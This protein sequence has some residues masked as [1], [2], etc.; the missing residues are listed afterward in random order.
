M[1]ETDTIGHT[2][3]AP[4]SVNRTFVTSIAI[5]VLYSGCT[6][7]VVGRSSRSSSAAM[8][9]STTRPNAVKLAS[10]SSWSL[11][12][13]STFGPPGMYPTVPLAHRA[14][15][16]VLPSS[17]LPPAF[18]SP[19]R[20]PCT[21]PYARSA[22]WKWHAR[23]GHVP[24]TPGAHFP[25]ATAARTAAAASGASAGSSRTR[26]LA[27]LRFPVSTSSQS[28]PSATPRLA[29]VSN[30]LTP[31]SV[32]NPSPRL[33]ASSHAHGHRSSINAGFDS[34]SPSHA[35]PSHSSRLASTHPTICRAPSSV[36]APATSAFVTLL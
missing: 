23:S 21:S 19:A 29:S 3:V 34:H 16:S 31:P 5:V 13:T 26:T 9:D 22:R 2:S 28:R 33:C 4:S 35:Q 27:P 6:N 10:H 32:S 12:A 24:E 8:S 30:A 11:V 7:G 1:N 20:V 17:N 15:P 18:S 14:A 25:A 36:P